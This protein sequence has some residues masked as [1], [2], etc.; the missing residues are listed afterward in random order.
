MSP[1]LWRAVFERDKGY[2]QYCDTDLLSSF[3]TYFSAH[4][5]HVIAVIAGGLDTIENFKLACPTCNQCLS[6][7]KNLQTYEERKA[8]VKTK[9]DAE[10][11]GYMEW[12]KELREPGTHGK[13]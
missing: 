11:N 2:C 12:R 13:M 10:M 1:A 6:R 3:S 8:Y 4:V 9:R 5:D 7:A